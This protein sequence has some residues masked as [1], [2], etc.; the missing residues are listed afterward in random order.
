MAH[1]RLRFDPS[2]FYQCLN[3]GSLSIVPLCSLPVVLEK[4]NNARGKGTKTD[5][6]PQTRQASAVLAQVA[7]TSRMLKEPVEVHQHLLHSNNVF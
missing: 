4:L 6:D 5:I 3:V 2:C 1:R 7:N